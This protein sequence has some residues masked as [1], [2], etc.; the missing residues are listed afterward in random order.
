MILGRKR[1]QIAVVAG[2]IPALLDLEANGAKSA[3]GL[4]EELG[5]STTI[6]LVAARA[7]SAD[8]IVVVHGGG[9]DAVVEL[10]GRG[11]EILAE[12]RARLSRDERRALDRLRAQR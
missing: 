7:L 1:A 9:Q 3:A 10:A 4:A 5:V 11:R 2:A 8:R 12:G 6:V